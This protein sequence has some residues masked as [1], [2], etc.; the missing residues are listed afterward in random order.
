MTTKGTTKGTI[1][2]Q[3]AKCNKCN[4]C[5]IKCEI[6]STIKLRNG[7]ISMQRWQC[8]MQITGSGLGLGTNL[9]LF[10]CILSSLLEFCWPGQMR[11]LDQMKHS[12][13]AVEE[14]EETL[15]SRREQKRAEENRRGGN[16][17]FGKMVDLHVKY[18]GQGDKVIRL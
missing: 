18:D 1:I 13:C 5:E 8:T 16:G 12:H 17:S 6:K 3:V 7:R 11:S 9:L 4:Q 2:G 10:P 15:G 14:E